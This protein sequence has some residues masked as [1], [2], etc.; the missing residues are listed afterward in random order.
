LTPKD[1]QRLSDFENYDEAIQAG[2]RAGEIISVKEPDWHTHPANEMGQAACF[3]RL[4]DS[5]IWIVLLPERASG[6]Y[7]K[8][9]TGQRRHNEGA[10]VCPYC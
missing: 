5:S 2:L 10:F 8:K 4:D 1:V 3:Q 7:W 9:L 6:G